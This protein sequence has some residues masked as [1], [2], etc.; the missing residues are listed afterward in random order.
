MIFTNWRVDDI[1]EHC[2]STNKMRRVSFLNCFDSK[3]C[4]ETWCWIDTYS[5]ISTD[6]VVDTILVT[7]LNISDANDKLTSKQ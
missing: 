4:V 6:D 3:I 1:V 7:I 2:W 5:Q